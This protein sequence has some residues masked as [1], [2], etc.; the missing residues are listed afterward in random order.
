MHAPPTIVGLLALSLGSFAPGCDDTSDTTTSSSD[1]TT[2]ASGSSGQGSSGTMTSTGA[3]STSSSSGSGGGGGGPTGEP[4]VYIGSSDGQIRVME[5]D[6]VTGALPQH[7]GV[8]GDV[9]NPSFLAFAPDGSAL[10]AADEGT[11]EVAAFAI[12]SS[13]DLSALNHASSM[14][15]GPAHVAVD[16]TGKVVVAVNYGSGDLTTIP[17]NAD[18]SLGTP[19]APLKTG[20]NAHQIVFDPT[21]AFAF[22]PN[23]GADDVSQLLFDGNAL[24]KNTPATVALT[25]GSGPRH[26]TF[27]PGHPY[28][29]VVR[30]ND[31]A[32]SVFAY[33]NGK[34][35]ALVQ[36]IS[37]L[38]NGTGGGGNTCA[39]IAIGNADFLYAS[40]RGHDSIAVFAIDPADGKLA[41]VQHQPTGGDT[42]RH[43]SID[44]TGKLML[45]GNQASSNVAAFAI[46]ASGKLSPLEVTTDV[47][48]VEFVGFHYL[49]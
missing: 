26:M 16:A 38:P 14:G 17:I 30:E 23:K 21:N 41:L 27:W 47:G 31:D 12:G 3:M 1:G 40:N 28:A 32:I 2:S 43:F 15:N 10:Y 22:V 9:D 29:Y 42:P 39:E 36:E 33:A 24:T 19:T 44:A 13:G 8:S 7:G 5:V 11:N 37:T 34:L 20:A 46:D 4:R 49:K 25:Q 35:G 18:G 45:V 48:P 6:L